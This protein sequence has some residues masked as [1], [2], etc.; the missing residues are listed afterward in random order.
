MARC[1]ARGPWAP[2]AR[3]FAPAVHPLR[4]ENLAARIDGRER[5]GNDGARNYRAL[6]F[7]LA[8]RRSPV[9]AAAGFLP[10]ALMLAF[11]ASIRLMT[12]GGAASSPTV[13]TAWPASLLF[14]SWTSA[15]S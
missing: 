1:S 10:A 14:S 7:F 5:R 6:A 2:V 3:R 9:L 8:G 12:R 11:S 15:V 4:D 13:S